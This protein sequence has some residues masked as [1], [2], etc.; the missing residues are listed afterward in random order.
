MYKIGVIGDKDSI[1]GF[2]AL[3][4]S[5]F[6][7]TQ[8]SEAEKILHEMA[9]E[10][11]AVIYVTEQIAKDIVSSIDQYKDSRFPAIIPIP[12]N[13]GALGIGMQGIKKSVERA[14]GADILFRD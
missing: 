6:P 4:L 11:Y 14:V 3:G 1:L 12:G 9:H 13:Q 8:P 10:H 2:K 7:V 5:V